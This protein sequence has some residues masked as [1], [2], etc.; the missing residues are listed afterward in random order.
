M[1]V[2]VDNMR[3]KFGR[4]VM[5][6]MIADTDAELHAMADAIGVSRRWWQAP[7]KHR[8][9]YD[10]A[11]SKRALAVAAGAVEITQRQCGCMTIRRD[12]TG[13]LGSP[14]DSELW[15]KARAEQVRLASEVSNA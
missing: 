13:A 10:I 11:L 7:P 15:L 3:A 12:A 2:Y 6:H 5:C 1:S 9:H 8:S 4:L 14:D